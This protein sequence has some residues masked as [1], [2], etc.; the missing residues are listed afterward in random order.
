MICTFGVMLSLG[1]VERLL[2][3]AWGIEGEPMRGVERQ[4]PVLDEENADLG[5]RLVRMD[6]VCSARA[7][8]EGYQAGRSVLSVGGRQSGGEGGEPPEVP[9]GSPPPSRP[10][11]DCALRV[12]LGGKQTQIIRWRQSSL[13]LPVNPATNKRTLSTDA[14]PPAPVGKQPKM[15]P[16][17]VKDLKKDFTIEKLG[18]TVADRGCCHFVFDDPKPSTKIAAFGTFF[19]VHKCLKC[20]HI[21]S[22]SDI[23]GTLIVT[24]SGNKFP[25][26][27]NDWKLWSNEVKVKLRA[28]HDDQYAKLSRPF[29]IHAD[30]SSSWI[31]TRSS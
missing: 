12:M 2:G 13:A 1:R 9:D 26:D 23:D 3:A 28:L 18:K 19:R 31:D 5:T 14:N 30:L 24:K 11:P 7:S 16:L 4:S 10:T 20:T 15:A 25:K 21:C 8:C 29:E 22:A 17:F 27:E 6:I